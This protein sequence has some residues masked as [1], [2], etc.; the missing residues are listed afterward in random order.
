MF[1][2]ASHIRR[3]ALAGASSQQES[4]SPATLLESRTGSCPLVGL[5]V[6][7]PTS[8]HVSDTHVGPLWAWACVCVLVTFLAPALLRQ[9]VDGSTDCSL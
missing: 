4:L 2:A 1:P 9:M 7:T 3:P 5:E 8:V 6:N